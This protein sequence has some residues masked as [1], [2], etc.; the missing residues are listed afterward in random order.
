MLGGG[1]VR[2]LTNSAGAVTDTYEYDACGNHWTASGRTP[3]NMLYQGEE[4]DPDLSAFVKRDL[5]SS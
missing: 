4:W 3:N 5:G 2:N 1:C